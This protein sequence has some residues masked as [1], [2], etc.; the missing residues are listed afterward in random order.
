MS[1]ASVTVLR[2]RVSDFLVEYRC[3][4]DSSRRGVSVRVAL[5]YLSLSLVVSPSSSLVGS[6]SSSTPS[7]YIFFDSMILCAVVV[8][9]IG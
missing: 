6:P 8:R 9:R 7:T 2:D 5:L 3:L 4:T 1:Q